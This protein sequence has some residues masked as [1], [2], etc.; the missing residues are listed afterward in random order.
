MLIS[1]ENLDIEKIGVVKKYFSRIFTTLS[2]EIRDKLNNL[3]ISE[4][5]KK[6]LKKELAFLSDVKQREY[7]DEIGRNIS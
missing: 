6:K 7:L 1:D 5:R 4:K 3:N 2:P